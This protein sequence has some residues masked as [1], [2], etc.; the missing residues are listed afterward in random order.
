M[1]SC[2]LVQTKGLTATCS[3][4]FAVVESQL[5]L[6]ILQFGER[7]WRDFQVKARHAHIGAEECASAY[8]RPGVHF[9]ELSTLAFLG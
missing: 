8:F 6:R 7:Q 9:D 1:K 5:G 4:F 2:D 3:R